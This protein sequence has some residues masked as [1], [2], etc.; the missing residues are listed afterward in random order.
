MYPLYDDGD[1]LFVKEID[2]SDIRN[3]DIGIFF[4]IKD[5]ICKRYQNKNGVI[6][7][8]SENSDEYKPRIVH[9]NDKFKVQGKVLGKYH[10]D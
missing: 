2:K 3:N 4:H 9:S 8:I 7:L 5:S 6:T 1:I 10:V